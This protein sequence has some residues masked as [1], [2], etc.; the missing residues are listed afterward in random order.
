[1]SRDNGYTFAFHISR[2]EFPRLN[3]NKEGN[4]IVVESIWSF[5]TTDAP[6]EVWEKINRMMLLISKIGKANRNGQ[7]KLACHMSEDQA[8][9]GDDAAISLRS[10]LVT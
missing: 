10:G 5:M 8:Q 4:S 6:T 3:A 7:D 1:M 9:L 2:T